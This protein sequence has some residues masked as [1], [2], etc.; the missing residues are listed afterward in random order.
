[1]SHQC[2]RRQTD[3]MTACDVA[4]GPVIVGVDGTEASVDALALADVLGSSLGRPVLLA[5][6]H[7]FKQLS[8]LFA[9]GEYERLVREV[10]ETTFDQARQH[11]RSG[12]EPRL[13]LVSDSSAAAGLHKLAEQEAAALVVIGSSHRSR[14]GRVIV[15][16]T[17]ERLLS[18]APAPVAVAPAGYASAG[19]RIRVVGCG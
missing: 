15:G 5:H 6:V 12:R 14:I 10:A 2:A 13:R 19:D 8:S 1:M 4:S 3:Q 16:G 18:G 9:P 11:L 17:G 7:P